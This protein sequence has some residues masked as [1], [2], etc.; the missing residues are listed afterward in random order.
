MNIDPNLQGIQMTSQ[1]ASDTS[2]A[3]M[4]IYFFNFI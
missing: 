2:K 1:A 4:L 3:K